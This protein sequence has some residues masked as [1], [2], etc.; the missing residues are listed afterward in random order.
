M[1]YG[2]YKLS[3]K[4]TAKVYIGRSEDIEGR[5][6]Q[7]ISVLKSKN[8]QHYNKALQAAYDKYGDPK[9]EILECMQ[10]NVEAL[11]AR[12][13]FYIL[14]FN[15]VANGFNISYGEIK[16]LEELPKD[17]YANDM[18][19]KA[20]KLIIAKVFD[21]DICCETGI[22]DKMINSIKQGTNYTWLQVEFHADYA[23]LMRRRTTKYSKGNYA[24]VLE[25]R[26]NW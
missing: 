2:I 23:L 1:S 24:E 5:Y 13:M 9:L 3:F 22:T 11:A 14:K 8:V 19:R 7:H 26:K 18:I 21:S 20:F 16:I 12:E 15:S 6:K 25:A 17:K 4:E 10:V